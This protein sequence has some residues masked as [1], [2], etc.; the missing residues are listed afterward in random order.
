M[1]ATDTNSTHTTPLHPEYQ[2]T[3]PLHHSNTQ[4]PLQTSDKHAD[5]EHRTQIELDAADYAACAQARQ[6]LYAQTQPQL[7]AYPNA[8]PQES[9]HF[10]TENQHQL[11]HLLH[12]IGEGA[13]LGYPVPRAEIR[14]G[15]GDWADSASDFDA[16]CWCMWGRFGTMGRQPIVTLLL[17][18]QRDGLADWNVVRCRGTGFR[19]HDSEDGVS[20]WRQHLVFLLGGHGRRVQLERPSAGEAQARGLL[21]RIRITPISTSPRPKPPQPTISTASHPHAT[22]RPHHTLFPIPSTPSATVHNPQNYAVRLHAE[23]TRTWRWA[24]RGER[25]AWMP[26]ETFTCPKDKRPW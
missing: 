2:H 14:R 21:P 7:H 22:T 24:R 15:G 26:A 16:D 3:L 4:P 6:H 1:P 11:T 20:V 25:G 23:T 19:A 17:A 12:N 10:S 8:N 5:E 18:R 9:A 13:A